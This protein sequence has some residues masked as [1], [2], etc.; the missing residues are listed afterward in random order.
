MKILQ[1]RHP[2][3]IRGT[4]LGLVVFLSAFLALALTSFADGEEGPVN[5]RV[6]IT[7]S[8]V[9]L[10]WD[11]PAADAGSVTGYEIV[12]RAYGGAQRLPVHP[13]D[14]IT[15]PTSSVPSGSLNPGTSYTDSTATTVD[16][17]YVYRVR[18]LYGDRESNWSDYVAVR[19]SSQE[20]EE[21]RPPPA[22]KNL[23]GSVEKG[24]VLLVWEAPDDDSVTGYQILRKSNKT[25]GSFLEVY[26]QD[27]GDTATS[28]ADSAVEAGVRYTYRVKAIGTGGVG[29]QSNYVNVNLPLPEPEP[30]PDPVTPEPDPALYVPVRPPIHMA[31]VD[32][33]YGMNEHSNELIVD[34]TIHNNLNSSPPGKPGF[35]MMLGYSELREVPFYFGLQT[36]VYPRSEK[37][38]IFSRWETRD[39]SNAK[40]ADGGWSQSAGYEGD[41]IGVRF[42]YEWGAGSYQARIGPEDGDPGEDGWYGMWITDLS[43]GVTTWAGSLKFPPPVDPPPGAVWLYSNMEIYGSP[44]IK[45]VDIAEWHVSLKR[46]LVNGIK[47]PRASVRYDAVGEV[48]NSDASYNKTDESI[49]FRAGGFTKRTT[50][51]G[52]VYFR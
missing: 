48:P 24:T 5:L 38:L 23:Q 49:H 52:S 3:F 37:G 39:L 15:P 17:T 29:N 4:F 41:F 25:P 47:A 45:P 18:A 10:A 30:P 1:F 36:N 12:R 43:T 8:E 19:H 21:H 35:Y 2:A 14:V 50:R 31:S 28:Y 27:T 51:A 22:P 16:R 9:I 20:Q 34:F 42:P 6:S 11:A 40:V 26:V 44:S 46:P 13:D 7:G 33:Y 32:W